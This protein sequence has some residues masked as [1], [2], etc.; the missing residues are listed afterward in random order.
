MRDRIVTFETL[1][2]GR[3]LDGIMKQAGLRSYSEAGRELGW[4]PGTVSRLVHGKRG[5][6]AAQLVQVLNTCGVTGDLREEI[7]RLRLPCG[8]CGCRCDHTTGQLA[9]CDA[10]ASKSDV[11]GITTPELELRDG[12]LTLLNGN[13]LPSRVWAGEIGCM[14]AQ[15]DAMLAAMQELAVDADPESGSTAR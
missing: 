5:G 6:Q 3:V 10:Q 9:C 1:Y 15:R 12:W 2:L 4:T 8:T 11:I 14:V 7:L 13:H